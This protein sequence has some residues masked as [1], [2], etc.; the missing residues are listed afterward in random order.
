MGDD[1]Y[2]RR[3]RR[4]AA[5]GYP[6]LILLVIGGSV[7]AGLV[8]L[9]TSL[10]PSLKPITRK[11]GG[12]DEGQRV[13]ARHQPRLGLVSRKSRAGGTG[14]SD[15]LCSFCGEVGGHL[16]WCPAVSRAKACR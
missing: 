7:L 2:A 12:S 13:E 3:N 8:R 5:K 10:I 4:K 9:T 14:T 1:A 15:S 16:G 6:C 11:G